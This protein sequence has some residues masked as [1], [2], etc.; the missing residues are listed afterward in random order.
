MIIS[1]NNNPFFILLKK[2][3]IYLLLLWI[4]LYFEPVQIGPLKISQLWKGLLVI[5]LLSSLLKN[6]FPKYIWFGI[7]FSFKFLIYSHI[8]YGLINNFRLFNE[9][10][11]FPVF[12]GYLIIR[13]RYE[14]IS[15]YRFN[16][17]AILLSIFL[18]YSAIP[19]FFGLKSLNNDYDLMEK[20]NINFSATKGLFYHI[21]SASKMFTIA[22]LYLILNKAKFNHNLKYRLFWWFSILLG[23]F[24]IIMCWTRTG[25]FIYFTILLFS[26]F[27]Y[28]NFKIK[29]KGIILGLAI[30]SIIFYVFQN[31]QAFRW[32]LTGGTNYRGEQ[33][34]SFD[35]LAK[36]RLPYIFVAIENMN[37]EG[38]MSSLIGYGEQKGQDYFEKKLSMS[39]TSHNATFEI[40]ESNGIIG[41]LIY[42]IFIYSLFKTVKQKIKILDKNTKKTFNICI[43]LFLLFY[44][45]S[46]GTPLWGEII[47]I[48][49][50]MDIFVKF[51]YKKKEILIE[52]NDFKYKLTE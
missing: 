8:P 43:L 4:L 3:F 21:A 42:I 1:S 25:W 27:H 9:S 38:F 35:Q 49:V 23:S 36:A 14:K 6:K 22:T 40:L 44:L 52:K 13:T 37:D 26:V 31:N 2:E 17:Y 24:L 18:I 28:T 12:L 33:E 15:I 16:N 30:I 45:T 51:E 41:L 19:F 47:F 32:R 10:L 48:F 50:I 11:V 5:Y 39:I 7:L 20:Y 46:H 34:L 29:L